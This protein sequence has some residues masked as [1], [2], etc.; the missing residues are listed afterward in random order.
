MKPRPVSNPPNPWDATTVDWLGEPPPALPRVYAD[1]TREILSRNDSPD[2]PFTYSVNPYRGCAHACAYCYARPT[3]EYLGFGA[4]T[5]FDTRIVAKL[6][7]PELLRR[8]FE[9]PSWTGEPIAFSGNTDAWQPLEAS[10]RLTRGCLEV[11]AEYRNPVL[12]TTKA[13]L[14]ER[15]LDLLASLA[16]HGAASVTVTLPFLDP[17]RARA[18]E[19]WVAS[20]ERRLETIRRIAAAGIPVG[21]NLAPI[22]PGLN[23]EEIP[24]VLAAAREAGATRAH[25]LLLRLPGPVKEVFEERL[26]AAL[27]ERADRVLHRIRETRD[28]KLYDARFGVRGRGEGEYAATIGAL[29]EA[30]AS[31]LGF[32]SGDRPPSAPFRRPRSQLALF[33]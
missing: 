15:D 12:V 13:P 2:I 23:D 27:P 18:I 7:A 9:R 16:A 6:R 17:A 26:R 33:P 28:G 24:R 22:V 1:A 3:H 5:D 4:G 31:R 20:P 30:A 11:C 10:L 21:V 25:W 19:P 14:V 29:F 8:A 32:T